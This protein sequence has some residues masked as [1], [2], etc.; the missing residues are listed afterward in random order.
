[1]WYSV[2]VM[3]EQDKSARPVGKTGGVES[4]ETI[5][6]NEA[7][8]GAAQSRPAEDINREPAGR[9]V[10]IN[11]NELLRAN[12]S[13]MDVPAMLSFRLPGLNRLVQDKRDENKPEK[14]E[15][16]RESASKAD[17]KEMEVKEGKARGVKEKAYENYLGDR[18]V[19]AQSKHA[20]PSAK[21]ERPLSEFEKC[22]I[23]VFEQ[24]KKVIV[25]LKEGTAKFLGKTPEQW[26]AFFQKFEGR[27]GKKSAELN[28][29]FECQ[30][31]D[32]VKKGEAK[33][34]IIAD[35][36]LGNGVTDKFARF[37]LLQ[38]KVGSILSKLVP[39]DAIPKQV[40]ASGLSSEKLYYLALLPPSG[41]TEILTG[42]KQ[43]MGM[44]TAEATEN[45]VS[46]ELGIS[47][48]KGAPDQVRSEIAAKKLKKKKMGGLFKMFG[49]GEEI[50]DDG[51][52]RFMPWWQ[53]GTLNR[54]GGFT[55]KRAFYSG[56]IILFIL[57]ILFLINQYLLGK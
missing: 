57:V 35:I 21:A 11:P 1:M 6:R 52:G 47:Q 50:V 53:W 7:G 16:S 34:V 40:I 33:A 14:P 23:A 19:H 37:G 56:V 24:A 10:R 31:R 29:I 39:G 43:K 49:D 32:M 12:L 51:S 3:A 36:K 9:F 25:E 41:E 54:P 4:P 42:T 26:R 28:N 27:I 18:M 2:T 20:Q 55:L 13:R 44:F 30:Y 17:T 8:E 5:E 22:L 45:R 38:Q 46:E 48:D 15:V